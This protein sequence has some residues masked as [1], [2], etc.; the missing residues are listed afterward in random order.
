MIG[1]F[2]FAFALIPSI[3]GKAKPAR[4]SCVITICLLIMVG[5]SFATLGLWLSFAAE[6]TAIIAWGIL[7]IQKRV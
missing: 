7:L 4:M 2:G 6:V 3:K 1:C 5:V